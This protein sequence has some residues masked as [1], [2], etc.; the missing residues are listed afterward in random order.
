MT[1]IWTAATTLGGVTLLLLAA[2]LWTPDLDRATLEA[3]YLERPAD[4]IELAGTRLHVRER[5]REGAPA[6]VLLHGFGGSLHT[7]EGWAPGLAQTHRVV[8]VDLPGSGLS[9][10]DPGGDYSD[11]RSRQLLLALLERL[12]LARASFV[13]HSIGG[14]I[15]WG[16]AAQY[17]E[18]VERLVLVSPDGFAS[19]GFEYGKAA[20]VPA[21][22]KAMRH[23]L[24]KALLNMSLRPAYADPAALTDALATRYH[25]LMRGTG[26]RDAMLARLEQT[27]LVDPVPALRSLRA[28]TLLLWG[29][30]D[31]MIPF[32]NA[33]DY[34][35]A[36]PRLTLVSLPGVGHVPQEEAPQRSLAP[37]LQFLR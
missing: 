37:V 33:V 19:P 4:L 32:A 35:K 34:V 9:A 27:V 23:V 8:L 6:V 11:A 16:F 20:D 18:R 30:Q 7:W 21:S 26:V 3:R 22:L 29:E 2:W 31:K 25:D 12:G 15:A 5:G 13:G 14:R 17:P 24:P 36:V 10:P 28:P 1:S